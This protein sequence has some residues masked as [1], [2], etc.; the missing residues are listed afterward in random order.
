MATQVIGFIGAGQLGEPMVKRLLD[1]GQEV[2]VYARRG[3]VRD[4]LVSLGA[5]VAGSVAMLAQHSDVLISC[6][7]SDAQLRQA[8]LGPDGLI[9]NAKRG[10]VFVS[11]TTGTLSTLTSL[12]DSHPS[13]PVIVD[14]PVSGTAEDILAGA[15]TVLIGGPRKAVDRAIPALKCYAN[16]IVHTGELGSALTIKLVNNLLF[17]ANAQLVAAATE[18]GVSLGVETPALLAALQVCSGGSR[19]AAHLHAS[20]DIDSFADAAG[21]FLAKDIAA[22]AEFAAELNV[23]TGLLGMVAESGPLRLGGTI[24]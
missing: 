11:H 1:G 8:G 12:R 20:R 6:L 7:F 3:D 5:T 18:L 2:L 9:A 4:R 19:A 17:A 13:P 24:G 23:K 14:A 16:P 22:C 21:P 10:A 15:L